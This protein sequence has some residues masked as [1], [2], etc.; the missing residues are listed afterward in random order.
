M[1]TQLLNFLFP[2]LWDVHVEHFDHHR[3]RKPS[4]EEFER[5]SQEAYRR[6]LEKREREMS[7]DYDGEGQEG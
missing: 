4:K 3:W 1:I 5:E 2:S 6:F 7:N